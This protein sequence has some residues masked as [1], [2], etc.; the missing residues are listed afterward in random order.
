MSLSHEA[1]PESSLNLNSAT[2]DRWA[3]G[4]LTVSQQR[5]LLLR[6]DLEPEHWKS[7]ALAFVE[8]QALRQACRP[9][10]E[11][12]HAVERS[13]PASVVVPRPLLRI[14]RLRSA[15]TAA[16]CLLAFAGGWWGHGRWEPRQVQPLLASA[17]PPSTFEGPSPDMEATVAET[18]QKVETLRIGFA[19]SAGEITRNVE[20]PVVEQSAADLQAWLSQTL[21]SD[22]LRERVRESGNDVHEETQLYHVTL[23]DGRE[24]L[25]PIHNIT[26]DRLD[27][28]DFQ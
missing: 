4:E 15:A 21:V 19:N 26:L 17:V 1:H 2:W 23:D 3:D 24:A 18:P 20:V 12:A 28:H 25:I 10:V 13:L 6:L 27:P 22:R 7:L 9:L 14:Q 11:T 8:A 16:V 5:E